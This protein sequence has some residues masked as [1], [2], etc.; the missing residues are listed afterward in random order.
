MTARAARTVVRKVAVPTAAA[1][2]T[3]APR[4]LLSV[5]FVPVWIVFRKR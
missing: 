4:L 1:A 5:A 2:Q 3:G